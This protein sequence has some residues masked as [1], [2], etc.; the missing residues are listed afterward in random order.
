[1]DGVDQDTD[2]EGADLRINIDGKSG[3]AVLEDLEKTCKAAKSIAQI[4]AI[5]KANP[6]ALRKLTPKQ[7]GRF[8][9]IRSAIEAEFS[10]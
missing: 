2:S 8:V 9:D 7:M 6:A 5:I 1:M 4:N 3:K 10:H